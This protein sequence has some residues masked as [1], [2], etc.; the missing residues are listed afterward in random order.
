MKIAVTDLLM[1]LSLIER[2]ARNA[3]EMV[4]ISMNEGK[5]ADK[6]SLVLAGRINQNGVVNHGESSRQAMNVAMSEVG[7]MFLFVDRLRGASNGPDNGTSETA[8]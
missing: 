5:A 4:C 6:P 7:A 1:E 3:R 8:E 2:T